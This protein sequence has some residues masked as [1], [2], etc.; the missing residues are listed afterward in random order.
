MRVVDGNERNPYAARP[1]LASY[2]EGCPS[3]IDVPDMPLPE[4]FNRAAGKWK[5]RPALIFYG[6]KILYGE[7]ADLV[8]RFAAALHSL[9]VRK[10]DLVALFLLN[11]PQFVIAYLGSLKVGAIVVPIDALSATP[12]LKALLEDSGARTIVCQDILFEFVEK[13]G[14]QLDSIIV[15]GVGDYLSRPKK[16]FGT[17][18]VKV[19]YQKMQI[20]PAR[21]PRGPHIYSFQSLLKESEPS[22]PSVDIDARN[23]LAVLSYTAGTTEEA[24]GVMLSHYNFLAAHVMT[25]AV[26][27]CGVNSAKQLNQGKEVALAILPFS[28][29]YGQALVLLGGLLSGYTLVML[30]N[31]DVE[32]IVSCVGRYCVTF[33]AAVPGLYGQLN[34]YEK[35]ER[36]SWKRVKVALAV[37]DSISKGMAEDWQ[38]RTGTSI[39]EWYGS[40]ETASAVCFNPGEKGKRGALGIPL[41]GT[42]AAIA[43]PERPEMLAFGEVGELVVKGPQLM[44]GYWRRDADTGQA[45]VEI[46]GETWVRTGDMARIDGE[47]CFH[48][49]DR[50][51]D[52]IVC[53]ETCIFAREIEEVL[54]THPM[55]KEAAII[56]VPD[57]KAGV[58]IKAVIIVKSGARGKVSDEEI[59]GFC[60][61]RLGDDKTPRLVE[62]RGEIP[63][64]EVGKVSRRELREERDLL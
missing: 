1:W 62:F 10:G 13:A 37:G 41:P 20:P 39:H 14:A 49:Y 9:G 23:D 52:R 51:M 15:A 22:P 11:C 33:L 27:S 32:D 24:K 5:Y 21:I 43:H 44:R 30:T 53:R 58:C 64:T 17:T 25:G 61:E 12:E 28:H 19:L 60:R 57:Q 16:F 36:I 40:T 38:R 56:G 46:D 47:G 54:K 45:F 50:K 29:I 35:T 18:F 8:N 59:I 63:K 48:F 7:L 3:D 34:E 42:L 31:P 55:V 6:R 4:A 2:P 26:W